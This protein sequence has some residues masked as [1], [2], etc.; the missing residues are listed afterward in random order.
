MATA[1]GNLVVHLNA[2]TGNFTRKMENARKSLRATNRAM[3]GLRGGIT[4]ASAATQQLALRMRKTA[5]SAGVM[6]TS[7]RVVAGAARMMW[8][9]IL[10]PAVAAV[11]VIAALVAVAR[12]GERFNQKM[13][14]SLAIMGDVSAA[15]RGEMKDAAIEAARATRFSASEMAES[16][17]FLASAGLDAKQS[18]AALPQVAMFAQ[19]G[20]F[21]V[22]R[23]TDLATDA[24]SALG[25]T[26]KDSAKNLANLT[27]V[28][29]VLTKANTIANASTEQFSVSLTTKAGAALKIVNKDIEEGVAVLAAF[30]DQGVK[31]ADSGTGLNIVLRD[32][33]TKAI[34]FPAQFKA[35]GV[36]VFDASGKMNNMADIVG[37]LENKLEGL[38]DKQKKATLLNLGFSDK[39]VIFIQTLIGMSDKIRE[40]EAALRNAGGTTKEVADKQLT[41]LQKG[42]NKLGSAASSLG[43]TLMNVVGPAIGTVA[44]KFADLLDFVRKT[45]KELPKLF[46]QLADQNSERL[47]LGPTESKRGQVLDDKI[48][49]V[50]ARRQDELAS[51]ERRR[52]ERIVRR[53]EQLANT[54]GARQVR[55]NLAR[56]RRAATITGGG[57]VQG[58][59]AALRPQTLQRTQDEVHALG[60]ALESLGQTNLFRVQA[61]MFLLVKATGGAEGALKAL[62]KAQ[63]SIKS[64]R[65]KLSIAIKLI[66]MLE[67]VGLTAE[68]AAKARKRAEDEFDAAIGGP[69]QRLK[70]LNNEYERLTTSIT[71][72]DQEQRRFIAAGE[73]PDLVNKLGSRTKQVADARSAKDLTKQ[74]MTPLERA[75]EA[76]QNIE[77]L[78]K[79]G[80]DRGGI[81]A[82]TRSR[83]IQAEA[84]KLKK[85]DPGARFAGA[86]VKGSQEAFSTILRSMGQG[87]RNKAD[88]AVV[89]NEKNT[90]KMAADLAKLAKNPPK[91][92][93]VPPV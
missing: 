57:G 5:V 88:A 65:E 39:S 69:A 61:D 22:A 62:A 9:A 36:A 81:S 85:D 91:E 52:Q 11:A 19:A 49:G 14:Q 8:T 90:A 1:A 47:G 25:L 3:L 16:Y 46:R 59:I 80:P 31:G 86:Q 15:M 38:S 63:E 2:R 87:K 51:D 82:E 41:A 28:T 4:P 77:R 34:K 12:A 17:F 93:P 40:Y 53:Q 45:R 67:K 44:G 48:A 55:A 37:D 54:R 73:D 30:A 7:F 18:L 26:V 75:K 6:A 35:A 10:G 66:S 60:N 27:R 76:V 92:T 23:A 83:A 84:D 78:A 24:Q 58:A 56:R 43:S 71:R 50:N 89:K 32:L 74:M 64:P 20:N 42:F 21:D 79:L 72:A 68:Q 70:E 29:D 33:Q 13:R